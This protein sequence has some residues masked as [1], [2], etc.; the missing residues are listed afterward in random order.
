MSGDARVNVFLRNLADVLAAAAPDVQ[1]QTMLPRI[2]AAAEA[3]GPAGTATPQR[4]PVCAFLQDAV[5]TART[6]SAALARLADSFLEIEPYLQWARRATGGPFANANWLDGH[7]NATI[8][9]SNGLESRSGLQIGVSLMA[10]QVRYPDHSHPPEEVYLV[11]SP[12][13]FQH[14]NSAWCE[15]GIGG[16]F[17]NEPNIRHAMASDNAPLFAIWSLWTG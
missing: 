2:E 14:G 10:P 9:G 15:P 5:A 17:C 6:G 1:V 7:A 3:A 16:T 8:I 12:G 4:L 11:L 13:R